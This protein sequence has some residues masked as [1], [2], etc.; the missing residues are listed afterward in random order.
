MPVLTELDISPE[1]AQNNH[2]RI[3]EQFVGDAGN[4]V[5]GSFSLG[6]LETGSPIPQSAEVRAYEAQ[7]EAA[8]LEQEL[9]EIELRIMG[10][11]TLKHLQREGEIGPALEHAEASL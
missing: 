4:F 5:V 10:G 7:V 2:E 3:R 1:F 6:L 11:L 9:A 8:K